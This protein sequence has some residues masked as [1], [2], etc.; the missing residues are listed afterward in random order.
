MATTDSNGLVQLT[1]TDNINP[2]QT[3]INGVT[4]S[5]SAAFTSVKPDLV[6][7]ANSLATANTKK[8]TLAAIGIVGTVANPLLFYRTDESAFYTWNGTAWTAVSPV[9]PMGILTWSGSINASG[10][11][12]AVPY[13]STG[14]T[15]AGGVTVASNGLKVPATGVYMIVSTTSSQASPSGNRGAGVLLN[16]DTQPVLSTFAASFSGNTNKLTA[17]GLYPL[18]ANDIVK[19]GV[20][21]TVLSP[22]ATF[23]SGQLS[24]YKI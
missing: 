11:W 6:Y 24:L 7:K 9:T 10:T 5:V 15:L 14:S 4:S 19:S 20:F 17:V 21:S 13:T 3:T 22:G 2:L 16:S 18:S 8:N 12:E 1:V 23:T